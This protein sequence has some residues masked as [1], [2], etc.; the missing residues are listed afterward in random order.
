[1]M[2]P[3]RLTLLAA[4]S[5]VFTLS[6]EAKSQWQNGN[7]ALRTN[8]NMFRSGDQLKVEI[9]A[10]EKIDEPFF[11][12]VS[13]TFSETVRE[14]DKDG[15]EST[16]QEQRTRTRQPGPVIESMERFRSIILDDTFY[17]GEGNS[18]G[19]YGIEVAVFQGYT[20]ECVARLRSCVFYQSSDRSGRECSLYLRSLKRAGSDQWLIFEGAFS[21]RGRYSALLLRG[22]RVFKYIENG[23]YTGGPREL[24]I[25]S[26]LLTGATGQTYDILIHDHLNNYSSTLARVTIPSSN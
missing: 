20:K 12:Q 14:I 23:V 2:I 5:L 4:I 22:N 25:F 6:Q 17:F 1:M 9:L 13:Y 3:R 11:T 21:E 8:G 18:S 7:L 16:R 24:N 10:L 15:G 26:D 19:C